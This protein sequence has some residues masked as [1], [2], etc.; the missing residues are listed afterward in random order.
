[1]QQK[2][3]CLEVQEMLNQIFDVWRMYL[4][5]KFGWKRPCP[6]KDLFQKRSLSPTTIS[7]NSTTKLHSFYF[8]LRPKG[9]K[10]LFFQVK[11]L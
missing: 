10:S 8:K 9:G 7:A 2:N 6:K 3:D 5:N 11:L 4:S 1:M